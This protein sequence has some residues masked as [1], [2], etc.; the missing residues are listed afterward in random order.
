MRLKTLVFATK[1]AARVLNKMVLT[2]DSPSTKGNILKIKTA[3]VFAFG[4]VFLGSPF[5][6]AAETHG[7]MH[8]TTAAK[9]TRKSSP[10]KTDKTVNADNTAKNQRDRNDNSI[11]ADQQS[12]SKSDLNLTADIRRA[13]VK[14]KSLSINA[15]NVKIITNDG[16]VVLRGP[17]NSEA[18]KI[19]V[20]KKACEIAGTANVTD[21]IEVKSK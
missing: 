3:F 15:H 14:D 13:I 9:D 5:V 6:V 10:D 20:S 21:E 1:T 18:E 4:G 2:N 17:V 16:A 7:G 8:P 19:N 11:T 12:N